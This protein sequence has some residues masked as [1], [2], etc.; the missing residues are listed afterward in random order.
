MANELL[1][2]QIAEREGPTVMRAE[3]LVASLRVCS[4]YATG[5]IA[6]RLPLVSLDGYGHQ[7]RSAFGTNPVL[8]SKSSLFASELTL[9]SNGGL[10]VLA[11]VVRFLHDLRKTA[12][13]M[14]GPEGTV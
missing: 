2:S 5:R 1:I 8:C 10:D 9:I 13:S 4:I 11:D 3:Q 6:S 7:Q 12:E 14:A